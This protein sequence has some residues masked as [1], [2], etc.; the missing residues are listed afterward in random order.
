M[1]GIG[2]KHLMM[3]AEKYGRLWQ[4]GFTACY[5][6]MRS[7]QGGFSF[8]GMIVLRRA[9]NDDQD[10]LLSAKIKICLYVGVKEFDCR[11]IFQPASKS[12]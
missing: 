12:E 7:K 5:C 11:R 2:S 4:L 8:V 9:I 1:A 3:D 10:Y 6:P